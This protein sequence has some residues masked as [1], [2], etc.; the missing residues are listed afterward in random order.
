MRIGIEEEM[1]NIMF[2]MWK[3]LLEL[4]QN[5]RLFPVLFLAPLIQLTV[6]GYA[7]TTDVRNVPMLVVDSDRTVES[8][9]LIRSFDASANFTIVDV[10]GSIEEVDSFL[11]ERRAW[12]AV[13]IPPDFGRLVR[14][15]RPAV[16]QVVAAQTNP[17]QVVSLVAGRRIKLSRGEAIVGRATKVRSVHIGAGEVG[18][19]EL[20]TVEGR[21]GEVVAGEVGAG[22]I[23]VI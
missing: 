22:K 5:P 14:E 8:R 18:A 21:I 13:T 19:S 11:E 9:G 10:V 3:E 7:A 4:R 12:M 6:L 16:V 17:C 2:V 15:G 20:G 23:V 1:R